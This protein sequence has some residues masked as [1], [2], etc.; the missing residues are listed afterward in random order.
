MHDNILLLAQNKQK[1]QNPPQP[2]MWCVHGVRAPPPPF[3]LYQEKEPKCPGATVDFQLLYDL[4]L[5]SA[6]Q[7]NPGTS[8]ARSAYYQVLT[9]G[10]KSPKVTQLTEL[11]T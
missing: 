9:K 3:R 10:W 7:N 5:L 11:I 4:H 1:P 8:Q 6:T 2:C